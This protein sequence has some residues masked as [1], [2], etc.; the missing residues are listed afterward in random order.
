MNGS[1]DEMKLKEELVFRQSNSALVGFCQ[2]DIAG[3][4]D[5]LGSMI[6]EADV[7]DLRPPDAHTATHFLQFSISSVGGSFTY[8]LTHL[9]VRGES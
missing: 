9:F 4:M 6:S 7:D 5:Q 1:Y 8:P 2:D 3:I